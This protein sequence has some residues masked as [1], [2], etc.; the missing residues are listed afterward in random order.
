MREQTFYQLL[1]DEYGKWVNVYDWDVFCKKCQRD[2]VWW[3]L[4][5]FGSI[6][7]LICRTIYGIGHTP[8]VIRDL[9]KDVRYNNYNIVSEPENGKDRW[10]NNTNWVRYTLKSIDE[11]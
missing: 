2:K 8:S 11:K 1:Y 3:H 7:N 6:T 9:R 10:G 4:K 5:T